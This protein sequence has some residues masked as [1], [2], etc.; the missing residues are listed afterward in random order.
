MKEIKP[1]KEV[2]ESAKELSKLEQEAVKFEFSDTEFIGNIFEVAT[3]RVRVRVESVD[4]LKIAKVD[5][6]CAIEISKKDYLIGRIETV[7]ENTSSKKESNFQ[8]IHFA[9]IGLI[10]TFTVDR[11]K[12]K[13]SFTRAVIKVAE[14]ENSCYALESANLSFFMGGIAENITSADLD[15]GRYMLDER[16]HAYVNG[17][18]LFQRHVA[19]VGSTGCGKSWTVSTIVEK[20]SELKS[21]NIVIFDIHGEYKGL[22]YA[23]QYRIATP[24]D[25]V[26]PT[27]AALFVP[28]WFLSY[29]ELLT[30]LIDNHD[31]DA[32]THAL[33]LHEVIKSEKLNFL[34][35]HDKEDLLKSFT[36]DS[37]IPYDMNEVL[38]KLKRINRELV[39]GIG[40]GNV[41]KGPYYGRF[42]RFI[43]RIE[44]KKADK[45]YNFLF[46]GPKKVL[47]FDYINKFVGKLLGTG[48]KGEKNPG[49]KIIDFSMVPSEMLPVIISV[50]GRFLFLVQFWNEPGQRHPVVLVCD[51]AHLYLPPTEN[52]NAMQRNTLFNFQRI[53]KEGRKYGI[54]LMVVSQRPSD[55]NPGILSQCGNL[56]TLRLTNAIDQEVV[57]KLMPD[58]MSGLVES[59]P[60][61][62]IGELIV[63]GDSVL[64]PLRIKVTPPNSPPT[65]ATLDFC[66]E[67]TDFH[68]DSPLNIGLDNMRKQSR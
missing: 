12:N 26:N 67:W 21:A 64:L 42:D 56:M 39:P 5:R 15:F 58:G 14:I 32:P 60:I 65:S 50:I 49:I 47:E 44:A 11:K 17:N 20:I 18:K 9:E 3:T 37:P 7:L 61:L 48:K 28:A 16:V 35:E 51:E 24:A 45:R 25:N 43:P 6:L 62:G 1:K 2:S 23:T 38:T 13:G 63:I 54:A 53:A 10:G 55:V 36:I 33:V 27:E 30:V 22:D 4:K 68:D 41:V 66:D 57:K 19:L 34:K 40:Q 31:P 46:E 8:Q 29:E 52:A 59:L